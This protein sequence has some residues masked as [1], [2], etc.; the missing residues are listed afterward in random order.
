[1]SSQES[2]ILAP[3]IENKT[4]ESICTVKVLSEMQ[5]TYTVTPNKITIRGHTSMGPHTG[6][7]GMIMRGSIYGSQSFSDLD[8]NVVKTDL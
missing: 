3:L 7:G 5:Y 8:K 2:K 6:M 1:M 4:I